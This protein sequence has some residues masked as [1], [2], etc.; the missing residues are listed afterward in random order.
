M[1]LRGQM[2]KPDAN[3]RLPAHGRD[4][5]ATFL[6]RRAPSI[7][8]YGAVLLF[9]VSLAWPAGAFPMRGLFAG[10]A[11][12]C[13]YILS[14]PGRSATMS[15]VFRAPES[16]FFIGWLLLWMI[17]AAAS[18][19]LYN[20]RGDVATATI[21]VMA[22]LVVYTAAAEEKEEVLF[23]AVKWL[24]VVLALEALFGLYQVYGPAGLPRTFAAM[25]RSI[26]ET[27]PAGDPLRQGMLH[28]VREGRASGTIGAPNIFASFC[29]FGA[30]A[31]AGCAFAAG[32]LAGRIGSGLAGAACV[33]AIIASGSN[34]GVAALLAGAVC[35]GAVLISYKLEARKVR[36][37][38]AAA[39]IAVALLALAIAGVAIFAPTEGSRWLGASG[40]AQRLYYWQT[41]TAIWLDH[42]LL[43]AGPGGFESYYA[44]Y[45]IPGSGETRL[46]HSWFF[47]NLSSIGLGI[48]LLLGGII[49]AG[50]RASR[51]LARLKEESMYRQFAA[52]GGI[53][54]GAFA[55]LF[56]GLAE[57]TFSFREGAML[58]FLAAG[59]V[60]GGAAPP[61]RSGKTPKW[62]APAAGVVLAVLAAISLMANVYTPAKG[63]M[64]R[65]VAS[66][67]AVEGEPARQVA[68]VYTKAIELDPA[69]PRNWEG[70][71]LLLIGSGNFQRGIADLREAVLRDPRSAR[72]HEAIARAYWEAGD[73]QRALGY[74]RQAVD[75]HPLD[76]SHRL[77]L[78]EMLLEIGQPNEAAELWRSTQGLLR[79]SLEEEARREQLG[80]RLGL[81][82]EQN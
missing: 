74:Q 9:A 55:I 22:F 69:D 43:G 66:Y 39:F 27:I 81:D 38:A 5:R 80:R 64:A 63:G 11:F 60:A 19:F 52:I 16:L 13:L 50:W 14:M 12:L 34:G 79:T 71:G 65:E 24:A 72:L 51:F 82:A 1:G 36:V 20:G 33:A 29:V 76:I 42:P 8:L 31:S 70:R 48:V 4:A 53:A 15:R 3:R 61:P 73:R 44:Q 58:F 56:H 25:E 6:S 45:R 49:A 2:K 30:L 78:A 21:A 28:A 47:L 26:L 41:A 57:Y 17:S 7:C 54:A 37:L 23:S 40:F 67:M 62:I 35:L 10:V 77:A 68:D 18:G 59:L 75:L 46:P 32:R